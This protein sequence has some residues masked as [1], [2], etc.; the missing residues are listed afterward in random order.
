M[1]KDRPDE[2]PKAFE[3]RKQDHIRLA[4]D[5]RTQTEGLSGFDLLELV[6][7]ALPDFNF[8]QI[9]TETSL[10][11][12]PC[13]SP[14]FISSMTAGH[15]EGRSLNRRLAGLADKK[16]ILMAV[17]SQRRELF[18]SDASEEWSALKAEFPK[19]QLI[20]NIGISQLIGL[21]PETL[22]KILSRMGAVGL[23]VH[24]NPLQ[25][26]LQA[27]G[28][29]QFLG[30][31]ETLSQLK[32]I[33]KIP[34]L[35]KEVGCGI[36]PKTILKLD[37]VGVDV[38]DIAGKGGTHW[39]RL[40]GLRAPVDSLRG[41]QLESAARVFADWGISTVRALHEAIALK[42]RA[43]I[44]ASGGVRNGL[45]VAKCL[46]LGAE[47]VGCALPFLAGALDSEEKLELTYEQML[48]ELKVAM[49]CTGLREIK[50]FRQN[51]VFRWK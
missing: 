41:Q 22:E 3:S 5:R 34:L 51:E 11:S 36:S 18:D 43:K 6:H 46:A 39:G 15:V 44:W 10:L 21:N 2:S 48:F 12:R 27:E 17:G 49:F 24:L 37:S 4:M 16:N 8:D 29:P 40:E 35:V 33:L 1:T 32:K 23:Y 42:P 9:N 28:T 20:A 30:G 19:L 14:L 7:E 13:Q 45:D 25:E 50:D 26:V 38:M 47:A 31:L